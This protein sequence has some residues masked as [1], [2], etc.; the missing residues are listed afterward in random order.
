MFTIGADLNSTYEEEAQNI[1]NNSSQS[2]AKVIEYAAPSAGLKNNWRFE[3]DTAAE[4]VI[5]ADSNFR[6]TK[7]LP[8][9]YEVHVYP[10]AKLAH[11][12]AMLKKLHLTSTRKYTN[13]KAIV[14]LIG[15][16]NRGFQRDTLQS[17]NNKLM[18]AAEALPWRVF[19]LGVSYPDTLPRDEQELLNHLNKHTCT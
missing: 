6:L 17:E 4:V 11:A 13:L 7:T 10:G 14:L 12:T 8:C 19:N 3:P 9:K 16:N 18:K 2:R 1:I 15:I 5:L